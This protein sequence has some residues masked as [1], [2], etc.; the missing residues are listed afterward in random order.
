MGWYPC[1]C[2]P[3]TSS[4]NQI[5]CDVCLPGTTP[6]RYQIDIAGMHDIFVLICGDCE[7]L[8]GTYVLNQVGGCYYLIDFPPIC[9]YNRLELLVVAH[10]YF[11]T[12]FGMGTGTGALGY[13]RIPQTAPRDCRVSGL[14]LMPYGFTDRCTHLGSTCLLTALT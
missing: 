5:H 7:S 8:D 4:P 9:G 12:F 10:G 3:V 2:P 1:C 14:S 11:A 6:P 13:H